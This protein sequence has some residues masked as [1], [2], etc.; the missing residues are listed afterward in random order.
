MGDKSIPIPKFAIECPG[1][2]TLQHWRAA[3]W[4]APPADRVVAHKCPHGK[5]CVEECKHG[6][7]LHEFKIGGT[8][9]KPTVIG[10]DNGPICMPQDKG[11]LECAERR[12]ARASDE[13][14]A[15]SKARATEN[16]EDKA[17]YLH[18]LL[19]KCV[20]C[21]EVKQQGGSGCPRQRFA[22]IGKDRVLKMPAEGRCMWSTLEQVPPWCAGATAAEI[23]V[24]VNA[25][26]A[27][28]RDKA[29]DNA[30]KREHTRVDQVGRR[31]SPRKT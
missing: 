3:K 19:N 17:N 6:R 30:R 11:C 15:Y 27:D 31:R 1:C 14:A 22:T 10:C 29:L 24:F 7:R 4:E 9:E 5:W 13:W 25:I 21:A 16:P 28:N 12:N 2:L 18:W 23:E 8:A 20:V 26:P